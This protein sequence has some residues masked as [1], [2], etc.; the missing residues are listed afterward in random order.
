MRHSL[1]A[2]LEE[3]CANAIVTNY[4]SCVCGHDLDEVALLVQGIGETKGADHDPS[5]W[6]LATCTCRVVVRE[7][8]QADLT[9]RKVLCSWHPTLQSLDGGPQSESPAAR[10]WQIPVAAKD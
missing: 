5:S 3:L 1:S 8:D 2:T 4:A 10:L 9:D 7:W 6:G